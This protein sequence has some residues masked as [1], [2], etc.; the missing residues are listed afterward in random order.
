M[1]MQREWGRAQ[2]G[3]AEPG[4]TR[5]GDM[6]TCWRQPLCA[7]GKAAHVNH[8]CIA[9]PSPLLAR[10]RH[11]AVC[12][13]ARARCGSGLRDERPGKRALGPGAW[14]AAAADAPARARLAGCEAPNKLLPVTPFDPALSSPPA[15]RALR[16]RW[17]SAGGWARSLWQVRT[18]SRELRLVDADGCLQSARPSARLAGAFAPSCPVFLNRRASLL[19]PWL[20]SE[21]TWRAPAST[22]ARRPASCRC[23]PSQT[24]SWP[25][26][27]AAP[28][29]T[30]PPSASCCRAG[31]ATSGRRRQ[32]WLP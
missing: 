31:S 32:R 26:T 18:N 14:G 23:Q 11:A 5:A 15:L 4:G 20:Q 28:R 9:L 2:H 12:G 16:L 8:L 19:P 10:R 27:P 3:T 29:S 17:T 21:P 1:L 22:G 25:S 30:A 7:P 13:G 24:A 6:P